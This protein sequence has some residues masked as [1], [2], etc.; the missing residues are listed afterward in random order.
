MTQPT[1]AERVIQESE[2]LS[3]ALIALGKQLQD[4]TNDL[5]RAVIEQRKEHHP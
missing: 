4:F 3:D 1:S 5:R 2:R